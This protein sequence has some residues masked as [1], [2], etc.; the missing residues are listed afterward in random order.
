MTIRV[1]AHVPTMAALAA[2]LIALWSTA[3]A[4]PGYVTDGVNLRAGPGIDYP[5]LAPL[6]P[7]TPAE[8]F[9][10]LDGWTWCDIAVNGPDGALR[11]WARRS[12]AAARL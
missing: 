3:D 9:G 4:A 5:L 12:P 10:C 1:R 7:G 8:I 6:P 2:G 11:G